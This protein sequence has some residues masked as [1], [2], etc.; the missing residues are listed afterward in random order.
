MEHLLIQQSL[1]QYKIIAECNEKI[2]KAIH[3]RDNESVFSLCAILNELQEGVKENDNAI[4]ALIRK[5]QELKK[6]TQ[7]QELLALMQKIQEWNRRMASHIKGIM[8]VQ[9]NE[10]QKLKKGNTVLQG[11]LPKIDQTGRRISVSN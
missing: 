8:A 11:Y 1:D 9:R 6:S 7:M 5:H 2:E 3:S 10:M 4:L